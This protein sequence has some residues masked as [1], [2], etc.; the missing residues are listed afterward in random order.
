MDLLSFL[1]NKAL[2]DTELDLDNDRTVPRSTR[3][4]SSVAVLILLLI[5]GVCLVTLATVLFG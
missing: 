1:R 3:K 5:G 2:P 4:T